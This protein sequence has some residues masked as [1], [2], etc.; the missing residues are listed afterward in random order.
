VIDSESVALSED[1]DRIV[2]MSDSS[3]ERSGLAR[4]AR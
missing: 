3:K 2:W 1:K 4:Q